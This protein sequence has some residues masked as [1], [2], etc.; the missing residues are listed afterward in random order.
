MKA[1]AGLLILAGI[2]WL[3]VTGCSGSPMA[4]PSPVQTPMT[5]S[6][7]GTKDGGGGKGVLCGD[8]LQLLDLY[9]AE[10]VY[11][12]P[13]APAA[14]DLDG[15]LRD[16]GSQLALYFEDNPRDLNDP[17]YAEEVAANLRQEITGQLQDIPEGT[18]L[19]PTQDASVPPLP[20]GCS[21][22]QIATN[23]DKGAT[24]QGNYY[25]DRRL[26]NKLS[27]LDQAALVLHEDIYFEA[28]E[29]G[30]LRSDEVR[31]L[32]GLLFARQMPE[33]IFKP[34]WSSKRIAHCLAQPSG[35]PPRGDFEFRAVDK[36]RDGRSGTGLYFETFATAFP[37]GRASV[38]FPGIGLDDLVRSSFQDTFGEVHE[39]IFDKTWSLELA[40]ANP[41]GGSESFLIRARGSDESRFPAFVSGG[42]YVETYP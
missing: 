10:N 2:T 3:V 19:P 20:P 8:K 26:W 13:I 40:P 25:R 35:S 31:R 5:M 11:H 41:P 34:I 18:R 12:L 9:E 21:I 16:F 30:A 24:L 39:G 14:P 29:Q 42:C 17:H 38:F 32:I 28:R 22:V 4:K 27:P 36:T 23:T 1:S 6:I 37:I 15:N 33:P 7:V